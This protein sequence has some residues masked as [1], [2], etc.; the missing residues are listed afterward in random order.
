MKALKEKRISLRSLWRRG[1]VIL[2]LFALILAVGCSDSDESGTDG[3][4]GGGGTVTNSGKAIIGLT[5]LERPAC[6][7]EVQYEGALI[8][9][10]GIKVKVLYEDRTWDDISDPSRFYA[11]P[12]YY[13]NKE[14]GLDNYAVFLANNQA[15][16]ISAALDFSAN[17]IKNV[18]EF[19]WT[20]ADKLTKQTYFSDDIIDLS[21]ISLELKYDITAAHDQLYQRVQPL[22][23]DWEYWEFSQF[24]DPDEPFIRLYLPRY[25]NN[26]DF[27]TA[28]G[29]A[30]TKIPL[31]K[32]AIH[33]VKENEVEFDPAPTW[34]VKTYIFDSNVFSAGGVVGKDP[35]FVN[36][37]ERNALE[38]AWLGRIK[39]DPDV[40]VKVSYTGTEET[41]TYTIPQIETMRVFTRSEGLSK[42]EKYSNPIL[43]LTKAPAAPKQNYGN[44]ADNKKG[45]FITFSYRGIN[46]K[47][48]QVPI[49]GQFLGI[50]ALPATEDQEVVYDLVG[51]GEWPDA[52]FMDNIITLAGKI[53]VIA[54]Y[55][56]YTDKNE[57]GEKEVPFD[58]GAVT[59]TPPSYTTNPGV[60]IQGA[61]YGIKLQDA[62]GVTGIPTWSA[63]SGST[64]E[65]WI[66]D[67]HTGLTLTKDASKKVTIN[68]DIDPLVTGNSKNTSIP[69]S[70]IKVSQARTLNP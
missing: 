70:F 11:Y 29:V 66:T 35:T 43:K 10:D 57:F 64:T 14:Y 55:A 33:Y 24:M 20:N 42:Y 44:A 32:G 40:R 58:G 54:K 17:G 67:N 30:E 61:S 41:R 45:A 28:Y 51:T 31:P 15:L 5:I 22:P 12:T 39:A 62:I 50:Q 69:V 23:K 34:P 63:P 38:Q 3:G 1:L 2:S 49:Y 6:E 60:G 56:L 47:S 68:F 9:L 36:M 8:K 52:R 25:D 4:G 19:R 53:K 18:K 16:N 46:M 27:S 65:G 13:L 26:G 48:L 59:G 21:G 7:G 37:A